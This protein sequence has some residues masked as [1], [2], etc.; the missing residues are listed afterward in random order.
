M[1]KY[2]WLPLLI[3]P[4]FLL[5]CHQKPSYDIIIRH[6][7]IYDGTGHAQKKKDIGINSDTIATIGDLSDAIARQRDI[8]ATGKAVSPGFIDMQSWSVTS[9]IQDGRS[10]G[11]I[12]QGITLEVFGEG[13]SMGPSP[14]P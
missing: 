9:L 4:L 3:S 14:T 10:M 7:A 11:A 1:R 12:R 5:S 6:G 13:S 2:S 8:D